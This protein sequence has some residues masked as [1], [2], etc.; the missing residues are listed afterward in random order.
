L[1][2]KF[3]YPALEAPLLSNG[4]GYAKLSYPQ[5]QMNSKSIS[6]GS[7]PAVKNYSSP[8]LISPLNLDEPVTSM[9]QCSLLSLGC[10]FGF[11]LSHNQ[12]LLP[13]LRAFKIAQRRLRPEVRS[14]LLSVSSAR[15]DG[16]L[17]PQAWRFV[18][19]DPATSGNCRVVTVAAKASSEHPDTI[20][21]FSSIQAE[22][23]TSPMTTVKWIIDSDAAL[24]AVSKTTKL[25]GV[26]T[27]QYR[28][29]QPKNA[30]EPMWVI[31]FYGDEEQ[32]VA[33]F[34]VGAKSA[35]VKI[36]SGRGA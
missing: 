8:V 12:E 9:M 7:A 28:L 1:E 20:E 29:S 5:S 6:N 11:A 24:Q 22:E 17:L 31:S 10:I 3:R 34:Q 4:M 26:K 27:A 25:K 16:T 18:F 15:S 33:R 35:L 19:L 30:K 36:L 21:A 2:L 13:A 14:K 32:P 23:A